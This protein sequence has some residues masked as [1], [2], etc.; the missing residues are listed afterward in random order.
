MTD[1]GTAPHAS[2]R[3]VPAARMRAWIA[4]HAEHIA[5]LIGALL[6][7]TLQWYPA[8]SDVRATGFGDW[9]MI[10]HN[11]EA[12]YIAIT[13]FGEWPLWDPFHCGGVSILGNPESQVY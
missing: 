5:A 12:A 4:A 10:H 7:A 3:E 6:L 11:W 8:F 13:R 9:Q 1:A 2:A